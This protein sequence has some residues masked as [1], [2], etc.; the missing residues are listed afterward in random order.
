MYASIFCQ[1]SSG[2][3]HEG[4]F[5]VSHCIIDK[6]NKVKGDNKEI[7]EITMKH[8][9]AASYI[10]AEITHEGSHRC[11]LELIHRSLRQR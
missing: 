10:P 2:Y 11:T 7:I 5:W 4:S 9:Q 1:S 8:H 3:L 6:V